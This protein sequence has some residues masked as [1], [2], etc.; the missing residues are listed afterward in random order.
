MRTK[1]W[2][3]IFFFFAACL[4]ALVAV[5]E[6]VEIKNMGGL[7]SAGS[8]F[9]PIVS[10]DGKLLFFTS[11]R[12][13]GL[14][15]QD[16]WMSELKDGQWSEPKN[17]GAPVNDQYNQGVDCYIS[18]NGK[19]YLYMTDCQSP[20]GMGMCD[21]FVSEK[22]SDGSWSKPKPLPAPINTKYS[23]ANATFDYA[24][25]I[26]YFV[27]TRPGGMV[28]TDDSPKKIPDESS[29]DIWSAVRNSDGSYQEPKNLGAP[30]NTPGWEGVAFFHTADQTLYFSS[31]GH[32][33]KGGADIFKA[34]RYQDGTFAEPAPVEYVN[35][36][37]NDMYLSIPA[38]GDVA[39]LSS[40]GG[41][42]N[43][44][45]DIYRIPLSFL[46]SPEV[47]AMRSLK[48]P[49]APHVAQVGAAVLDTIYFSFDHSFILDTETEKLDKVVKFLNDNPGV[50]LEIAGHT[51]SIGDSDY[52]MAL[53]RRRA[54]EVQAY[55]VGKGIKSSRLSVVYYGET[56]PAKENDPN[57]GNRLNRRVEISIV[58]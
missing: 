31:D 26:L 38:M 4:L 35:T 53:S 27:S 37:G 9:A 54:K 50:N 19:E 16:I 1:G 56:K 47:L 7:N 10:P 28:A 12:P 6:E 39:Y 32:G 30:I 52:N 57:R 43:G 46:L 8:D 36:S 34:K 49:T 58:K 41:S 14:G 5:G 2:G 29:Y 51:D 15:G 24:N 40:T 44:A 20:D 33:G 13:G 17:L 25:N 21:I 3:V 23:D 55:L 42:G 11:D 48:I 45:E 18:D 22:K